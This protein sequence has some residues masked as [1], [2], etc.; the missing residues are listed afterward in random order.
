MASGV[1]GS[2]AARAG[3]VDGNAGSGLVA[4]TVRAEASELALL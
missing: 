2:S 3:G 1:F 4:L